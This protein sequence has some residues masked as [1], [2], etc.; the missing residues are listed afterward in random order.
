MFAVS[1]C[2][3]PLQRKVRKKGSVGASHVAAPMSKSVSF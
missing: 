2:G 1:G 3:T